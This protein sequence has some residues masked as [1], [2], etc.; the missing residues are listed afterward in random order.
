MKTNLIQAYQTGNSPI[1]QKYKS[2]KAAKDFDINK[3]LSTHTFIKPLPGNG[4]LVKTNIFDIPS[5]LFKDFKYSL[6]SVKHA[7][8]GDANDHELGKINDVGM[9]LGGLAIAGYLATRKQT[10]L[11]KVME[12]VGLTSFFAAM[13]IWPK[14]ALQ[15][16]AYLIHGVDV[17]QQYVD[18]YG[19]KKF[20]YQDHQFIPWDLYSD[21]EI[22]KI[23]DRLGVDKNMKNRRAYIQEKM[24]KI[25]LQNNTMWMLTSGIATPILSALIC[26]AAEKPILRLQEKMAAQKAN[27]LLKNVTQ[28]SQKYK[29]KDENKQLEALLETYKGK[30]ITPEFIEKLSANLSEWYDIGTRAKLKQ[31]LTNL[32]GNKNYNV[33]DEVLGNVY[34]ALKDEF[35]KFKLDDEIINQIMPSKDEIKTSFI[36]RGLLTE[37]IK[38]LSEHKK[39][40]NSLITRNVKTYAQNN[41]NSSVNNILNMYIK[42]LMHSKNKTDFSPLEKALRSNQSAK[43]TDGIISQIHSINTLMHGFISRVFVLDKYAYIRAAQAPETMLADNW[44]NI[45]ES[46]LKTFN[47]T[48]SEIKKSRLD[49]TFAGDILKEKFEKIVS[50]DE[51]Y[52]QTIEDLRK[53]LSELPTENVFGQESEQ[54]KIG[55]A[56][57]QSMVDDVFNA[58]GKKLSELGLD[59]TA[60][61]V[62]GYDDSGRTS[63]KGIQKNFLTDR[64]RGVKSS[65]YRILNTLDFYR[66]VHE[67]MNFNSQTFKYLD[68]VSKKE[69]LDLCKKTLI[70]GHLSDYSVKL[71]SKR[72]LDHLANTADK[73]LVELANDKNFFKAFMEIIYNEEL[74]SKTL[75]GIKDTVFGSDFARYREDIFKF[76]GGYE[77]FPKRF[78]KVFD[79]EVKSGSDFKFNLLGSSLDEMF[80]NLCKQKFNSTKWLKTFGTIGAVLTAGTVL[81]QFFF[82]K[83]P[84]KENS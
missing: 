49:R 77:Y 7:I 1:L 35:K 33:D 56:K 71:Y 79:Y 57:Y 67:G 62:S 61:A 59:S 22:N 4:H 6:N 66:R 3:E 46:L 11:T 80:N 70:D 47:F 25:A 24:R 68:D 17:R 44:N 15:L 14:L 32:F 50:D 82:G 75:E 21:D 9:K 40:I 65:F 23:G 76:L 78:H 53:K 27:D 69:L 19:R 45:T 36:E 2:D 18:N 13:D 81:S 72:S 39:A 20:F 28:E 8:T 43:L 63:L 16:P 54:L 26:N 42:N 31:D 48:D 37:G 10:P 52:K 58:M 84:G 41:P 60:A 83:L 34:S 73:D 64:I 74:N 12:F 5:E 51:L 30:N 55:N 38:D 29:F